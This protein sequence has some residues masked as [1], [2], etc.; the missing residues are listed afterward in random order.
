MKPSI[1]DKEY[2]ENR[3]FQR[4]RATD[5]EIRENQ[6]KNRLQRELEE[7]AHAAQNNN[8]TS[9]NEQDIQEKGKS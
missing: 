2:W 9:S 7:R 1:F 5:E 6:R 3:P 4:G 8:S